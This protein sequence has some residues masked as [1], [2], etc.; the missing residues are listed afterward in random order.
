VQDKI[1]DAKYSHF[2][3]EY[4]FAPPKAHLDM[5]I[6]LINDF[7][8]NRVITDLNKWDICIG[9]TWQGSLIF[10]DQI[11]RLIALKDLKF[12]YINDLNSDNL[13][14]NRSVLL[15]D[16]A[17]SEN[18]EFDE[19]LNRIKSFL[20]KKIS[21]AILICR[22]SSSAILQDNHPDIEFIFMTTEKDENYFEKYLS[23]SSYLD[24]TCLPA[25]REDLLKIVFKGCPD[26]NKIKSFF[27]Q[28]GVVTMDDMGYPDRFKAN[29]YISDYR[30]L[31]ELGL[32]DELES[33]GLLAKN[34]KFMIAIKVFLRIHPDL[35]R[36]MLIL[37]PLILGGVIDLPS[38]SDI[39]LEKIEPFSKKL[40]ILDFFINKIILYF[41]IKEKIDILEY[42]IY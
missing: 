13:I 16:F 15:F 31:I 10:M 20:P 39:F 6:A 26:K 29:V 24:Y 11:M 33:I 8:K 35:S 36:C 12:I 7:F 21:V 2:S 34:W 9:L 14:K 3:S 28:Y 4:S 32:S 1:D 23:V 18:K 5:S 40:F 30:T 17:I 37:Q 38:P 41:T 22:E 42:N 27:N 19:H 25:S